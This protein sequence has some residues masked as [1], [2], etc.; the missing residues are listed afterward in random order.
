MQEFD[1]CMNRVKH[2]PDSEDAIDF[3]HFLWLWYNIVD[4]ST[5]NL[6]YVRSFERRQAS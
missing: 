4:S 6:T 1:K 2:I 5:T 3:E